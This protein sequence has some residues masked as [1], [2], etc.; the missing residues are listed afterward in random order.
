VAAKE[1]VLSAK[2][3]AWK[4]LVDRRAEFERIKAAVARNVDE[5]ATIESQLSAIA[6]TAEFGGKVDELELAFQKLI[7]E[8]A[9]LSAEIAKDQ[10]M[11]A[12]VKNG[13]C[14]LLSERCL[15]MKEGQTL[16]Q[17]FGVQLADNKA[18]LSSLRQTRTLIETDLKA[19]REAA[20]ALIQQSSLYGQLEKRREEMRLQQSHVAEIEK[21]LQEAGDVSES[22]IGELRRDLQSVKAALSKARSEQSK[23]ESLLPL[24]QRLEEIKQ[25]GSRRR[26]VYDKQKEQLADLTVSLGKLKEIEDELV[27]LGDPRGRTRQ[28]NVVIAKE[29]KLQ[30]AQSAAA[31]TESSLNSEKTNT[32]EKLATFEN[33]DLQWQ[34]TIATQAANEKDYQ[35]YLAN[36]ATSK[37][38]DSRRS[39][40]AQIEDEV[41][42][43]EKHLLEAKERLAA[44]EPKYNKERHDS[45]RIALELVRGKIAR[46][47]AEID[48][49][50][51]RV[52][53]VK[54]ELDQLD[55]VKARVSEHIARRLK[56][57]EVSELSVFIRDCLKKAGPHITEAYLYTI[58]IKANQLFR[59]ISGNALVNLKWDKEYEILLEEAGRERPF[60]NLSG[61]EQMAA[62][63][64]VR[65]ALLKE[66]SDLRIA[67]F[68]EPTTNMDEERRRNLAQ[69]IGHITD[70]DQ[71]FIISH[72]DSFEGYTD[73]VINIGK[74]TAETVQ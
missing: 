25:E 72:D 49:A 65:L 11:L 55:L 39:E 36:L 68:D 14:P 8:T 2:E 9:M 12:E 37:T 56:L 17:F 48:G 3:L 53:A 33:L 71:L 73:E 43:T 66:L 54:A 44:L 20:A 52:A 40:L 34:E 18:R 51:R 6:S 26:Q 74:R 62:A 31:A 28:L 22:L 45:M 32:S 30:E 64:A 5:I 70:F 4:T 19:A 58:S 47:E 24:R 38:V 63:L 50:S 57:E 41:A 35:D 67:F 15:N 10:K 16:D 27:S 13:L 7:D 69:Q 23:Y 1:A 59:D 42:V 46:L 61:G 29:A 21:Y 60:A